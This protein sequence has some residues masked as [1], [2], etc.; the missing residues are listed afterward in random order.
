MKPKVFISQPMKGKTN[1]EIRKA[2][3]VVVKQCESQG[4]EII[5]TIF[6]FGDKPPIYYLAKSIEA[7]T[8]ADLVIF[9]SG[10]E[11]TR[12]CRIEYEIA[13]EY[14]KQIL[15]LGND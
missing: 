3:E 12:G 15:I 1:E 5:D 14:G 11:S 6:D 9:M 13:K 7:M 10:W 2:R 8:E 4:Y